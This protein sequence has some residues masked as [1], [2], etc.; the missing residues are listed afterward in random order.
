M[1]LTEPLAH[2][3]MVADARPCLS[4]NSAPTLRS[5]CAANLLDGVA[6][7][8][9]ILWLALAE[10]EQ[11]QGLFGLHGLRGLWWGLSLVLLVFGQ[12]RFW[13]RSPSEQ[14]RCVL[15]TGSNSP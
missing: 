4:E 3:A 11:E 5:A 6:R 7:L 8:A 1:D 13:K 12:A 15:E 10:A 14:P 9:I 2:A